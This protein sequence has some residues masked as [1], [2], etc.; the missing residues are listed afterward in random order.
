MQML[1]CAIGN[2]QPSTP[3]RCG[4]ARLSGVRPAGRLFYRHGRS[5]WEWWGDHC[6][7][8]ACQEIHRALV[9]T[10]RRWGSSSIIFPR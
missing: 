7:D 6:Y 1:A 3:A 2:A 9:A 10:R 5:A 8:H 4:D